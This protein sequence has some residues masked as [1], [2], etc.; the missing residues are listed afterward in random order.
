MLY[1]SSADLRSYR[2]KT[3]RIQPTDRLKTPEEAIEFVNQRGF[4]FFWPIQRV[5]LPSLWTAVAGDRPV[6]DQHDDPGHITW[7]WKDQLLG[8]KV[9]HYARILC[10]RNTIISLHLLP[11]FYALSPNYGDPQQD[12]LDQYRSGTLTLEARQVYEALLRE[13]PLDTI[14]LRKA[15]RLSSTESTSRFNRA[16]ETLQMEFKILP[17][18]VAQAGAWRYAFIYDLVH[19]HYPDLMDRSRPISENQARFEIL[20]RYFESVGAASL[21]EIQ[22]LFGWRK[23]DC[24]RTI[25]QLAHANI[26]QTGVELENQKQAVFALSTFFRLS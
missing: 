22:R 21:I 12:Y 26:L 7:G 4:I 9:W 16:L 14:S 1:L 20:R 13:G 18:G 15:A 19:R 25:Q 23:E 2:Q 10:H 6:A 17:I 11:H 24:L 8:K 5:T 3:F